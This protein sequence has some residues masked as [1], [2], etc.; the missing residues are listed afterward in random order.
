[1]VLHF[2]RRLSALFLALALSASPAAVC[3]G[4]L[5]TPEA[6]MACCSEDGPCPMHQGASHGR[7]S[8][9]VITQAQADSCCASSEDE[10]SAQ[11]SPTAAAAISSAVLGAGIAV[12]TAVPT[13]VLTD[14]WR[15][16]A[17]DPLA[18]VPRH[19]LLSVYLV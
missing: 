15:T 12:P 8:D 4:W 1:M 14:G 13:L 6:R 17:P 11:S 5:P 3:A 18:P 10:D 19:V 16:T 7:T 9:R 2:G